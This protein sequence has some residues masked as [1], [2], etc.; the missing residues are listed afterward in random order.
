MSRRLAAIPVEDRT[1][2]EGEPLEHGLAGLVVV[3][4]DR[5]FGEFK[6]IRR[7]EVAA[8]TTGVCKSGL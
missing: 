3:N 4:G 1:L 5:K 2:D 7:K 6:K 8:I